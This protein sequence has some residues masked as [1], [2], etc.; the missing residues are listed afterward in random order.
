MQ[1]ASLLQVFMIFASFFPN[2]PCFN[3]LFKIEMWHRWT[4]AWLAWW[5]V[6]QSTIFEISNFRKSYNRSQTTSRVFWLFLTLPPL[7]TVR[8]NKGDP[9]SKLRHKLLQPIFVINKI[10]II[11]AFCLSRYK[12]I[13]KTKWILKY[14]N[15]L[16][17][18][19]EQLSSQKSPVVNYSKTR[20]NYSI[21]SNTA[22]YC[23]NTIL[24]GS[25]TIV[26]L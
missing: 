9:P 15:F 11:S 4:Q 6:G 12:F 5:P 3:K 25:I 24:N 18:W 22:V 16:S 20:Q 7:V 23:S 8:Y 13:A 10:V 21:W 2:S 17:A 19:N 26:L 1:A 14:S